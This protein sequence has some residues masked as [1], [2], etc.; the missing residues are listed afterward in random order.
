[1]DIFLKGFLFAI[2]IFTYVVTL[3]D[4]YKIVLDSYNYGKLRKLQTFWMQIIIRLMPEIL[5]EKLQR[6]TDDDIDIQIKKL[7]GNVKVEQIIALKHLEQ[8]LKFMPVESTD[9]QDFENIRRIQRAIFKVLWHTQTD[10]EVAKKA[11]DMLCG[12]NHLHPNAVV[13]S[14]RS[15]FRR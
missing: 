11:V 6:F 1:M 10:S 13:T 4:V 3:H 8:I 14:R 7:H 2:T 5:R 12:N 15:D 9:A